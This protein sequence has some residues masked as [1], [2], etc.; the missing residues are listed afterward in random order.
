MNADMEALK[1]TNNLLNQDNRM[2]STKVYELSTN[3]EK[4]VREGQDIAKIEMKVR[5]LSKT[6]LQLSRIIM[7]LTENG[8]HI[9][10]D[11]E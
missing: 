9:S 5:A 10:A 7:K 2:L 3:L 11:Q 4:S 8:H 6:V 1:E